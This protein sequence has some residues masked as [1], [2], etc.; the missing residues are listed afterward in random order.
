MGSIDLR[1]GG[2]LSGCSAGPQSGPVAVKPLLGFG[3]EGG[4]PIRIEGHLLVLDFTRKDVAARSPGRVAYSNCD[5][6][7][8]F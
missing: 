7:E 3:A 8:C 4:W 1:Q 2:I 5:C 6:L